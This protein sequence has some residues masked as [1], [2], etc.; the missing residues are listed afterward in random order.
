MVSAAKDGFER[1][2]EQ[3]ALI[4]KGEETRLQ[5][6]LKPIQKMAA[7]RIRGAVS[8]TSVL[9]DGSP[10]GS[11]GPDGSLAQGNIVPGEH[12]IELRRDRF[13]SKKFPKSFP[14]GATVEISE[15]EMA[16]E[17]LPGR[18]QLQLSPADSRVVL[19]F[20]AQRGGERVI[21]DTA[22]PLPEGSYTFTASA[23]NHLERSATIQ[24]VSGEIQTVDLRLSRVATARQQVKPIGMEG[25][26][27]PGHWTQQ[28][29]W[30]AQRGGNYVLFAPAPTNG[31]FTFTAAILR[32]GRLQWFANYRDSRNHVLLQIDEDDYWRHIVADGRRRELFKAKH[33]VDKKQGYWTI[34]LDIIAN[35]MTHKIFKN[36][37]W[38][39]LDTWTVNDADFTQG[40]FGFYIPGNDQVGLSNFSFLPRQ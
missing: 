32:G 29:S 22:L 3:L 31:T 26:E 20:T 21:R 38:T 17:R 39:V 8:G 11:V 5:F 23:P 18:V 6:Q 7:L 19:R 30:Q 36:D 15:S 13:S 24:V 10:I 4:R 34:S 40:K 9:I 2:A 25:W 12:V 28:G 27:Q 33:G 1:P 35:T 16:L 14:A 37:A